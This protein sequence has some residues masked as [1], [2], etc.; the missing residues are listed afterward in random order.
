[1][2]DRDTDVLKE[3]VRYWPAYAEV[4]K[5]LDEGRCGWVRFA[6]FSRLCARPTWAWNGWISDGKRSGEA[7]LDLHIHAVE[8]GELSGYVT[9]ESA[10]QAVRLCLEEI[11]SAE[12]K[13]E[14]TIDD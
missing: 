14:I 7:A 8:R 12:E 9:P 1:M 4:K 6:E 11:R 2:K 10:V 13:R 5:I 3:Y